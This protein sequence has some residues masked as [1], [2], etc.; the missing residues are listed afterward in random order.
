CA[1]VLT[2]SCALFSAP[3]SF[4]TRRSSDLD[5]HGLGSGPAPEI[6]RCPACL[7][8]DQI[9]RERCRKPLSSCKSARGGRGGTAIITGRSLRGGRRLCRSPRAGTSP[10]TRLRAVSR[11]RGGSSA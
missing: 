7:G 6:P 10:G 3:H 9:I 11:G 5:Q 8:F 2:Y 4:P 1:S